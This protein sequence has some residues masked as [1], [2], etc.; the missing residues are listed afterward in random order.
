MAWRPVNG[1]ARQIRR[2][3]RIR[4]KRRMLR[5]VQSTRYVRYWPSHT[6]VFLQTA[7]ER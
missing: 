3:P 5:K 1:I 6:G 2:Q 7:V 4:D